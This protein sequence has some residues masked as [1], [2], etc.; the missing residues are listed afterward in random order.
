M[1]A[2]CEAMFCRF[3]LE[4]SRSLSSF[5]KGCLAVPV[6]T[7]PLRLQVLIDNMALRRI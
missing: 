4:F 6:V 1:S 2:E 3:L 7:N 5:L